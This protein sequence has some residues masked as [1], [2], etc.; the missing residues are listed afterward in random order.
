MSSSTPPADPAQPAAVAEIDGSPGE[1]NDGDDTSANSSPRLSTVPRMTE[2]D[3]HSLGG[4]LT[5]SFAEAGDLEDEASNSQDGSTFSDEPVAGGS[6]E[7][8]H[9]GV[10]P[11]VVRDVD[12]VH[13]GN[14]LR[15]GTAFAFQNCADLATTRALHAERSCMH[16]AML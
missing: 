4:F 2:V 15:Q 1:N 7:G 6:T 8:D 16:F 10:G 3:Q 5:D 12:H 11:A 9:E 13:A 14:P